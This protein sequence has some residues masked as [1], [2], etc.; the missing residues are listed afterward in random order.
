MHIVRISPWYFVNWRPLAV[1]E[2]IY[3]DVSVCVICILA[4]SHLWLLRTRFPRPRP[5][6]TGCPTFLSPGIAP[7]PPPLAGARATSERRITRAEAGQRGRAPPT[8][9]C[10]QASGPRHS[11][12]DSGPLWGEGPQTNT[13]CDCQTRHAESKYRIS[14]TVPRVKSQN[15]I[16]VWNMINIL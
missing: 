2:A 3:L 9:C 7:P 11:R 1:S 12:P 13:C 8:R 6:V 5:T 14:M 15:W 4:T 10:H 16:T